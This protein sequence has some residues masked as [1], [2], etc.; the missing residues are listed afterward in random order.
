MTKNLYQGGKLK[1][2]YLNVRYSQS[3]KDAVLN[4]VRNNELSISQISKLYDVS[5]NSIYNWMH[6]ND[7]KNLS[8][9]YRYVDLKDHKGSLE[10]ISDLEKKIQQLESAL[11]DKVL[12]NCALQAIVNVAR[13][14]Y[15]IDLKKKSDK[16][17]SKNAGK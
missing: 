14:K 6:E 16:P 12:E 4:E 7:L 13:K 9:E 8:R 15:G 1:K 3:F 2:H 5:A 11:S 17:A 10:K